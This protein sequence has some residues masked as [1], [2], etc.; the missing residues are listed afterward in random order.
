MARGDVHWFSSYTLESGISTTSVNLAADSL[1]L[2]FLGNGTT[3]S[4]ALADP[5]WSTGGTTTL[6]AFEVG[7]STGY[8]TGGSALAS[9]TWAQTGNTVS[10]SAANFTI[11]QDTTGFTTAYWAV[12]YDNTTA[13]KYGIFFV[14]LGGP[15]GISAGAITITWAS[16]GI[17][18]RVNS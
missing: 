4:A 16:G 13:N 3:L 18:T 9:V 7:T 1:K 11:A 15:V 5:R 2:A 6:S 12:C 8:V 14:D 17:A 10:L